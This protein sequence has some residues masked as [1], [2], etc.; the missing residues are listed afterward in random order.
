MVISGFPL[1][2]QDGQPASTTTA[3]VF[4]QTTYDPPKVE[5]KCIGGHLF[6]FSTRA[7]LKVVT[8]FNDDGT[9]KSVED[10]HGRRKTY[11]YDGAKHVTTIHRG[12]V[13]NG[14][15][16]D[17]PAQQSLFAYNRSH[18]QVY[19]L[20]GNKADSV[21][22][23]VRKK[24]GVNPIQHAPRAKLEPV[25]LELN[26]TGSTVSPNGRSASPGCES[27]MCGGF[28]PDPGFND[29]FFSYADTYNDEYLGTMTVNNQDYEVTSTVTYGDVVTPI[30]E[31]ANQVLD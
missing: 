7:D 30:E 11:E 18:T 22:L 26:Q 27:T 1:V 31:F 28:G 29:G 24:L 17:D 13:I 6:R 4:Y 10:N 2:G 19:F 14:S 9:T 25:A 3:S 12:T 23:Q 16:V 20:S 21:R 8:E 15:F 5:L